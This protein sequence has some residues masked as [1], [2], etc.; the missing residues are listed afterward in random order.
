MR[1]TWIEVCL[2]DQI[3]HA[4]RCNHEPNDLEDEEVAD[5]LD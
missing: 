3:R 2:K 5:V 1:H 4:E